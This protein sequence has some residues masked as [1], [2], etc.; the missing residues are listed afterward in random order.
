MVSDSIK[1]N[2]NLLEDHWTFLKIDLYITK[3]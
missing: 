1:D 2:L 3:A